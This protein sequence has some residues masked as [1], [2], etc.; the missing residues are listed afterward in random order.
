MAWVANRWLIGTEKPYLFLVGRQT[1]LLPVLASGFVLT[2]VSESVNELERFHPKNS[3]D[4]YSLKHRPVAGLILTGFGGVPIRVQIV[5][6]Q[7]FGGLTGGTPGQ[8]GLW[9]PSQF[10]LPVTSWLPTGRVASS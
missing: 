5:P 2:D 9:P 3:A 1:D 6:Y 10:P 8:S 7:R 4:I